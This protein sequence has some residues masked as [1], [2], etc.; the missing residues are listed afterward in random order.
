MEQARYWGDRPRW[1]RAAAAC[2]PVLE[3]ERAGLAAAHFGGELLALLAEG[4]HHGDERA[5]LELLRRWGEV[6][7]PSAS[8]HLARGL[9]AEELGLLAE[10][11]GDYLACTRLREDAMAQ[12]LTVRPLLGLARLAVANGDPTTAGRRL[13]EALAAAPRDPE[14]LLASALLAR[15]AGPEAL[16]AFGR[17]HGERH[18][19]SA[20]LDAAVGEAALLEGDLDLALGALGAAAGSPPA[21]PA[22]LLLVQALLAAGELAPA[23]ALSARLAAEIP[24]AALGVVLADLALGRPVEVEVELTPQQAGGALRRWVKVLHAAGRPGVLEALRAQAG[25]LSEAFPWL[26]RALG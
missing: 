25:A 10:A 20:E 3:R 6:V 17:A 18:G 13:D 9:L 24:E 19:P 16:L 15:A 8:L 14:A 1:S 26:E 11:E 22:A 12:K 5:G 4:L 23:R 21:G 7:R 2:L